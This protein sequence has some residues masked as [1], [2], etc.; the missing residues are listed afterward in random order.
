MKAIR[1]HGF[2]DPE[3][4]KL[5]DVE[6][7]V[8]EDGEVLVTVHAAGV[9]PVDTY[10][11][12]GAYARLPEL[13]YIP[14][15]D[16]AG[17]VAAVGPGVMG[18]KEG[19]RVYVGMAPGAYAE[20][21]VCSVNCVH[22][23]PGDVS[24]E[25]GAALGIPY[26][27][28]Y[29]AVFQHAVPA[30]GEWVLIHGASGG[31]GTAAVQLAKA[32]GLRVIGTA[33][34]AEGL[35]I[36]EAQGA[37]RVLNHHDEAHGE[38]AIEVT[39]GKGVDVIIEMLATANLDADLQM[40]ARGGRIVVVGSRGRIEI[41]PRDLMA[42]EATVMG[43]LVFNTPPQARRDIYEGLAGFLTHGAVRPVIREALPLAEAAQ[44]HRDVLGGSARGK[45]VLLPH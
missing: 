23:L 27:T 43:M 7:P 38:K 17:E 21:M 24:Y 11:R 18:F 5:E 32:G 30:E 8:P 44:S 10:I 26:A 15:F 12:S 1:V 14:G 31:V 41:T 36:V 4:M 19:D 29:R 2:G 35:G 37:D 6:D 34:S 22:S 42:R 13:P 3:V 45:I 39:G 16:A 40:L 28:A 33:G 9:N 25:E 20:M